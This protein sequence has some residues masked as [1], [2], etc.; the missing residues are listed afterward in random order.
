M[1]E[2]GA[3]D[4]RAPCSILQMQTYIL[5]TLHAFITVYILMFSSYSHF[6]AFNPLAPDEISIPERG[7]GRPVKPWSVM[8][9][10][11]WW[12]WVAGT[13]GWAGEVGRAW[14]RLEFSRSV[15]PLRRALTFARLAHTQFN[16]GPQ[17]SL[18]LSP[19]TLLPLLHLSL[20]H[21]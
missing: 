5:S 20:I 8:T 17:S 16:H 1:R 7:G 6:D 9:A 18:P 13:L 15:E 10:L 21:I 4:V 11:V 2:E 12:L 14:V 19:S 3:D